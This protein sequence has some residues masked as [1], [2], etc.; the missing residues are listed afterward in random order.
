MYL[1]LM[2]DGATSQPFS[3]VALPPQAIND[4]LKEKVIEVSRKKYGK[5][6]ELVEKDIFKQHPRQEEENKEKGL[7]D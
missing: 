1:K 2:I 6:R 4:S 7:F 3:A 5:E